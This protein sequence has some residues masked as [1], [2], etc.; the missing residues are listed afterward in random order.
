M[1]GW[2]RCR[3]YCGSRLLR[4]NREFVSD[5]SQPGLPR[6][7]EAPL[8]SSVVV[9][10]IAG[11]FRAGGLSIPFA[12]VAL[13]RCFAVGYRVPC[14]RSEESA[15]KDVRGAGGGCSWVWA[16]SWGVMGLVLYF[17]VLFFCPVFPLHNSN[18]LLRAAFRVSSREMGIPPFPGPPGRPPCL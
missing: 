3:L 1:A 9:F 4:W 8:G 17:Y 2:G 12:P 5:A 10:S 18:E 13:Q 7:D 11:G 14:P 16:H 15:A 6:G